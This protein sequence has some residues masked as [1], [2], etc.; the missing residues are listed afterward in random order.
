MKKIIVGIVIFIFT[1]STITTNDFIGDILSPIMYFAITFY[2]FNAYVIKQRIKKLRAFGILLSLA[3][4]IWAVCELWWGI[5][6]L[7]L[8]IDPF[9]NPITIYGYYITNLMIFLSI[10]ISGYY[11]LKR[12]NK[13]QS[14][15]DTIIVALCMAVLLWLFVFQKDEAKIALLKDDLFSMSALILDVIIFAWIVI[16]TFSNR[17][18]KPPR[19]H[20][21]IVFAGFIYVISDMIYY[22]E[23]FYEDYLPN[24][25]VDGLYML[26][27][28][29]IAYSAYEKNKNKSVTEHS[30]NE[31]PAYFRLWIEI[32]ILLIPVIIFIFKTSEMEYFVFIVIALLIYY[33]LI[34][35]LQKSVFQAKLL[36]IEK[37]NIKKLEEK[38]E[39]R[40]QEIIH[41]SNI[42]YISGLYNRRYFEELLLNSA[43]SL[44]R[45]KKI[46]L[47]YVNQNKSKSIKHLYGKEIYEELI[48]NLGRDINKISDEYNGI[49]ASYG[50]DVFVVMIKGY[51]VVYDSNL[52]SERIIKRCEELFYIKNHGI[53]IG[54]NIGI[55]CYPKDTT[56]ISEIIK[57][58]DIAMV[59]SKT[60]GVNRIYVYDE[61]IGRISLDKNLIE[62]KLKKADFNEEF[63]LF[64]QLQVNAKDGSICGM[65]SLIRWFDKEEGTIPP[66]KFIGITEE[67]GLIVP[68]GYW[69]IETA[70]RRFKKWKDEKSIENRISVNVSVKQLLEMDFV[71]RLIGILD[72][73]EVPH[74]LFEIEITESFQI[75]KNSNIRDML[76]KIRE[77]GVLIAIDDFGTG[78]SSLYYLKNIPIDRIKIA[79]EL[80]DNIESDIYSYAIVKMVITIAKRQNIK[81]IAEGVEKKEQLDKLIELECDEIQGYYFAKPVDEE[82]FERRFL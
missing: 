36:E 14:I 32:I 50:E 75:E 25:W 78:Y 46:A 40:K 59:Q 51:D 5:Q 41:L 72:H 44:E 12:M 3:I 65:E 30:V 20:K 8:D 56:N 11:D 70:A 38:I 79:K 47:I 10:A 15:L 49:T 6:T 39:K 4:L 1:I 18:I 63:K 48:R 16:W 45:G 34:N 58:A 9:K 19:Y 52:I 24:S 29:F 68:L 27:F 62:I 2:V 67:I 76:N 82:E 23:Y 28:L 54:V 7:I 66:Y 37:E 42:D 57:N 60:Y 74:N 17:Y 33:I 26:G 71:E 21:I 77:Y 69:I 31:T 64:Y 61:N 80:I 53:K 22:Y 35:L 43:K 81:V 73:Y 13:V 55:A